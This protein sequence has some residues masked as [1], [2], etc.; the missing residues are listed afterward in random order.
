MFIRGGFIGIYEEQ[1]NAETTLFD[2]PEGEVR[3]IQS[4]GVELTRHTCSSLVAQAISRLGGLLVQAPVVNE[5][6]DD[7]HVHIRW[8]AGRFIRGW[9][10]I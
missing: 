6:L 2:E 3:K 4:V 8:P 5:I 1:D 9:A 10:Q 7:A